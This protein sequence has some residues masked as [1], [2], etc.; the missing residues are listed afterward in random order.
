M[1][2]RRSAALLSIALAATL[3]VAA[4]GPAYGESPAPA[5]GP[6][7]EAV[8]DAPATV[9][10]VTLITGDQ[11]AVT[12]QAGRTVSVDVT[13][14][15]RPAADLQTF[16]VGADVYVM[17]RE[18]AALVGSGQVDRRLFNV[19]QLIAQGYDDAHS[20]S[21]PTIVR[22]SGKAAARAATPIAPE[23]GRVTRAL[24]GVRGAAVAA[25]KKRGDAFWEA[26]DDDSAKA[27]TSKAR[28]SGGV[29]RLWLDGRAR[30]LLD[31]SVPQI[32]APEAW[33]AG[34]DGTGVKVA[35]LDTGVDLKHPDLA[36]RIVQS[37]S[38]VPQETVADGHGHG[39]HVA[40]TIAG[41]GAASGGKYK[42]V[43]PG[44]RLLVGK[45][46][47]DKGVG[48]ESWI[49]EGMD[50]AAHS[51]ARV[52]S[53]SI[54]GQEGGDG[55]DPLSTAVNELT[56]ET[57]VL[58]TIAAGNSGPAATTVGSP[59][60]ASAA[61]T[62]GA[63]D[64]ADAVTDFSSRGP[65]G[66]DG[67]L[68]P[69]IT[70]PGFKIVAAR[71]AG[72]GMG[73]PVDERYTT[74]SG[75]SMATPHVAGAAAI[76][77]QEHPD[78]TAAR[79]KSQLVSTARTTAGT[80]VHAQGA[81]RVDVARAV[82]QPVAGP[83][84]LD[85]GLM[86]WDSAGH[87]VRKEI[88]YANDG[89]QPVT[90]TLA[91]KG[92]GE[93][94]PG[95]M[96]A[97]G[98]E[99]VT[100]PA[101]G[102][103]AVPVTL[104]PAV[105]ATG[106]H[107]AHVTAASGDGQTVVTTAVGFVKDVERFDVTF[108][109]LDRDGKPSTGVTAVWDVDLQKLT[110]PEVYVPG[111]DGTVVA[112]LP[113]GEHAFLAQIFHYSS[114]WNRLWE[115]TY[116][117]APGTMIDSDRTITFDGSKAGPVTVR[118]PKPSRPIR[119]RV[120]VAMQDSTG[121]NSFGIEQWASGETQVYSIPS[122]VTS[123]H[124][125]SRVGW[126]LRAPEL[127]ARIAGPGGGPIEPVYVRGRA[128]SARID[129]TKV[130]R[131]VDAGTGRAEDYAG[132]TVRGRLAL[133]KRSADL[134]PSQQIGNAA[135]AGADAVVIYN[136]TPGNWGAD[137]WSTE[138][139]AIPA[140]TM[141]GEQ[142]ARLAALAG[143]GP[144]KV[145]FHGTAVSP[146]SY[147]LLKYHQGGVPADQRY[148]VRADELATVEMAFHAAA[149]RTEGGYFRL[150]TSPMQTMAFMM[151]DRN[152]M[153]RT[154]TEY[155][156]AGVRTWEAVQV[157]TV[158]EAGQATQQTLPAVLKPGERVT[159]E[160]NK[161][162]V[163]TALAPEMDGSAARHD[164]LGVVYATGLSDTAPHQWYSNRAFTD[165]EQATVYRNG[166]LLGTAP[167]AAVA[168]PVVP[169]RAEYR[170]V[171]DVRR[172]QPWWTT[173]T[174]VNTDW[175]FHSEQAGGTSPLPVLSVDYDLD[176]DQ[177]NSAPVGSALRVGLGLRYPKGMAGPRV[178]EAKLWASYDDGA[179]WQP[180][181]LT[182]AGDAAFTG[183][184]E[185]PASARAGGFVS[186]RVQA[187]DAGGNTVLQTVTRAYQLRP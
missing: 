167:S 173:S 148:R 94:L 145:L 81:G 30:A 150:M 49:L 7:T 72:T 109:V 95:G 43:A 8:P 66:G 174:K 146:Y 69:E 121:A 132:T 115:H 156:T 42:G 38:F 12:T 26:V 175:T 53:M 112:R 5:T 97:L 181:P 11:V 16:T 161:A 89:D 86:D 99:T 118:T 106:S 154:L 176:V 64:S 124:F 20:D 135:Q 143:R 187:T 168:F 46:L 93:D 144:V 117:A 33:A 170:V 155:V 6:V 136:D 162:V 9:A 63:V 68:K 138:E 119:T 130:L 104:D 82:R 61:L 84:V 177:A 180:V 185:N 142:G 103:A 182:A 183:A 55:T 147:E 35:V 163:R 157:G 127:E 62:V 126:S 151:S 141:T 50:W 25:D 137:N 134:T 111:E 15:R 152:V 113:R 120:G 83:G 10:R 54:G 1:P 80:P 169:E 110:L 2:I 24:P 85:F 4:T 96:L 60:A 153:P 101:H 166:E 158:W 19:T 59:G 149:P 129:G 140:M 56:A 51:G 123:G 139:T 179:T 70:A 122:Q 171:M 107:G 67:A 13:P 23:G 131:V 32:G 78:W 100:V 17:P 44:A 29:Q 133:V 28:L 31:R 3:A 73:T 65:R 125:E 27:G 39:T 57:G 52:V 14:Y 98:A 71:E 79:L 165:K 34:Y 40:S 164:G 116:G 102:T 114:D 128:G 22:Y 92:A 178:T 108:K 48:M 88:E 45:V 36:D 87:P 18:A 21:I 186:L 75:T 172:D 160:W 90:L 74:A 91:V 105:A 184:V 41:S 76:L 159:R 77:A 47:S 37:Q 58:F